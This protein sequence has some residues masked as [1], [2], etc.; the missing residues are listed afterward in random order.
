[1]KWRDIK[2]KNPKKKGK[3]NQQMIKEEKRQAKEKKERIKKETRKT[4]LGL[5]MGGR[6]P[7]HY[8]L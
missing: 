4:I 5:V 7:F 6:R 3:A 2:K 1:M 8:R